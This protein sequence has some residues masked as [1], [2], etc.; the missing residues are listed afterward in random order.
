MLYSINTFQ[1]YAHSLGVQIIVQLFSKFVLVDYWKTRCKTV[2][3]ILN[4]PLNIIQNNMSSW[5]V[6]CLNP[7]SVA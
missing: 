6:K 3:D 7:R 5:L 2:S 1:G 4:I